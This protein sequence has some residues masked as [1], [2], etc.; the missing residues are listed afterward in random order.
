MRKGSKM[1]D[2]AKRKISASL[3]GNQYRKGIPFTQEQKDRLS[4]IIMLE[5][6]VGDRTPNCNPQNLAAFNAAVKAGTRLNPRINP[7]KDAAIADHYRE[8]QSQAATGRAF[9]LTGWAITHALRRHER[10]T[11]K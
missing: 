10:R 3:A 2:E 11:G 9:G 7:E 8:T 6:A 4:Q 5:Y 1:P